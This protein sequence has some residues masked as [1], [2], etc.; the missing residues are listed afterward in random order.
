[1]LLIMLPKFQIPFHLE[2]NGCW[3]WSPKRSPIYR[4]RSFFWWMAIEKKGLISKKNSPDPHATKSREFWLWTWTPNQ[5]YKVASGRSW[6]RE[7]KQISVH[8]SG[9]LAPRYLMIYSQ[10]SIL[11]PSVPWMWMANLT[12]LL[13]SI[14]TELIW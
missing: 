2:P 14:I 11:S 4:P 10:S 12:L 6:V 13:L 9:F 5:G 1:M 8:N 7:L 3:N